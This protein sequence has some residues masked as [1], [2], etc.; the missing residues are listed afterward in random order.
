MN[1][2][3]IL[4]LSCCFYGAAES[5]AT[6]DYMEELFNQKSENYKNFVAK[7]ESWLNWG[8]SALIPASLI[9]LYGNSCV[10]KEESSLDFAL[11]KRLLSG[12]TVRDAGLSLII[13]GLYAQAPF[14][15]VAMSL[16][17]EALAL[18]QKEDSNG[19]VNSKKEGKR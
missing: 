12:K 6:I 13:V 10:K 19:K 2:K 18:K 4:I 16:R 8:Q 11:K 15:Y 3:K 9:A 7:A 1:V 14:W 17:E 5:K